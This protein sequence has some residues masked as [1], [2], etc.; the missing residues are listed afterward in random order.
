M[1]SIE[2]I[3]KIPERKVLVY[4]FTIGSLI[5][6]GIGYIYIT[7][8]GLFRD[9]E[10]TRLILLSIFYSF[11]LYIISLIGASGNTSADP[12]KQRKDKGLVIMWIS[13]I[14]SLFSFYTTIAVVIFMSRY[15]NILLHDYLLF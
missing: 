15:L 4:I 9:L 12:P 10:I 1:V 5:I 13:S 2:D 3:L 6:P 7:N 8:Y 14:I 11:P